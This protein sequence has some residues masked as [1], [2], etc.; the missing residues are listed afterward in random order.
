MET[1]ANH[2]YPRAFDQLYRPD[3]D[4]SLPRF[5]LLTLATWTNGLA[6]RN[7]EFSADGRP[8]IKITEIKL[9]ITDQTKF[10]ESEYDAERFVRKGDLL[11]SW[12]GQPETSID[13]FYWTG[14]DGW[15]NQHIYKVHANESLCSGPYLYFLLKYL[16]PNFVG[17][18]RNKQ[19]AGLG[20]VTRKDFKEIWVGLPDL[21][22]Q[23]RIVDFLHTLQVRVENQGRTL[24]GLQQVQD[25]LLRKLI[26]GFLSVDE[27]AKF[28]ERTGPAALALDRAID[29]NSQESQALEQIA[30][31]LFKFWFVDFGPVRA[32]MEGRWKKG[33]SLPGM[34]ADTWDLW[35][36]EF[37]DSEIGEIPK[38]WALNT[39]GDVAE[40]CYGEPL[41]EQDRNGGEVP[42]FGSNGIIGWHD[43]VLVKGPGI[44]VGRKGNPGTVTWANG[45][46]WPI[47]TTFYVVRKRE[48]P[49]MDYLFYALA[50][51]DL[52][53]LEA[54]S[55]VPGLNRSTA[56]GSKIVVPQSEI[57][58]RFERMATPLRSRVAH[59]LAESRTLSYLRDALLPKLLSGEIRVKVDS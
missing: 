52:P 58:P 30:R 24:V 36:S 25:F 38:G 48:S 33:E 19:T 45:D 59:N 56:I 43:K 26:G 27:A 4:E 37:E 10:T 32:K 55:A 16:R 40:F 49:P 51:M 42:V 13:A 47:D 22:S 17:I 35:P 5:P 23:R 9:G 57:T 20:H 46:F 18:A 3:F 31:A 2:S 50:R 21:D 12:S 28:L 6:F 44:V 39:V 53:S 41:K 54:D 7:F 1:L 15:L 34:P 14:P 11:F 29:T 8:V